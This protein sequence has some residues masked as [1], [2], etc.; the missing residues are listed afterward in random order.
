MPWAKF[1]DGC[2][3]NLKTL[4]VWAHGPG[5]LGAAAFGLDC[6][7]I[8]YCARHLTDGFFARPVLDSWF[9]DRAD[10]TPA[11]LVTILEEARRWEPVDG[12]WQIHDFLEYNPSR[13]DVEAERAEKSRAGAKGGKR[14]GEAR[15]RRAAR[16]AIEESLAEAEERSG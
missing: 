10:D 9:P 14:S 4:T 6:R 11:Q 12:G 8:I 13:E 3:D 15:R 7:A 5:P 2:S 16:R 1:D